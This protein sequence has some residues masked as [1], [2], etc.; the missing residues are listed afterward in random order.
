M[1][2][3]KFIIYFLLALFSIGLLGSCAIDK[4]CPAYTQAKTEIPA[5]I[6]QA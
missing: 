3:K 2:T 6:P 5:S 1:K 4:K